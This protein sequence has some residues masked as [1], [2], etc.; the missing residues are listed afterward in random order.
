MW[1]QSNKMCT[2]HNKNLSTHKVCESLA[3]NERRQ[4]IKITLKLFIY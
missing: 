3:K 2:S 1:L 4:N